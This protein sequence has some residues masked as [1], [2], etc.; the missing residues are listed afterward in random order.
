MVKEVSLNN[1]LPEINWVV[2]HSLPKLE[3]LL[4]AVSVKRVQS[5]DVSDGLNDLLG[6]GFHL[7]ILNKNS[8]NNF[9]LLLLQ[10]SQR[11]HALHFQFQREKHGP[12][13]SPLSHQPQR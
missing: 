3:H 6:H 7:N 4:E 2:H 5:N 1:C 13:Y 9:A 11:D 8:V 10:M 12:H